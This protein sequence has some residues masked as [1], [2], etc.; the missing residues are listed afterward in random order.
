MQIMQRSKRRKASPDPNPNLNPYL[1][2]YLYPYPK[3]HKV[4]LEA[5]KALIEEAK[6]KAENEEK[7]NTLRQIP[8]PKANPQP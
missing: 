4:K 1:Y 5:E 2:L 3:P 7:V 6:K 8:N